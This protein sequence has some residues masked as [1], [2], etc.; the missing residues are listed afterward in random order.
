[1][2]NDLRFALR[3]LARNPGLAAVTVLTL[4]L[5]IGASTAVFSF[6][7]PVL[8]RP[9]PFASAE[10][11]VH[12]TGKLAGGDQA[13]IAPP[14]YVDYRSANHR[15]EQMA[16]LSYSPSPASLTALRNPLFRARMKL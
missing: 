14:G 15:F 12:L 16:V 8:L 9:L 5:G 7:D 1:M 13:G 3:T 10:R 4:V 2:L 6:I 11:P